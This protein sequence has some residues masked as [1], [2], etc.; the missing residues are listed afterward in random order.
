MK[1]FGVSICV[2]LLI[3]LFILSSCTTT[4]SSSSPTEKKLKVALV[5]DNRINDH[6]WNQMAY[7]GLK[8]AG[9]Q[10]GVETAYSELVAIADF[11]KVLRDYASKGYDL[12]INHSSIAKDAVLNTAKDYPNLKFLWTDGDTTKDNLAV[13]VP[14]S[15]ESSYLAGLL[16]GYMTKSKI[17]GM[18]GGMDIPSA[19][20]SF[21]GFEMGLKAAAPDAKLLVN[22]VGSFVD[23]PAG[24][25]AAL[26]QIESGADV[27]WGNGDGQNLGVLEACKEKNVL[28]IGAVWDQ[29]EVAPSVVL[30]SVIWGLDEGIVQVI[31]DLIDG[32]FKGDFYK[33]DIKHGSRLAPYHDNEK[34]IP[35]EVQQKIKDAEQKI[36]N[37]ELVI[38]V[39]DQG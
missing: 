23:V 19:H 33:I 8:K 20:R 27:V 15:Q 38:P 2:C 22:W 32:K 30:T 35:A 11:E 17:I 37:G 5:L 1:K 7:E 31:Q 12:I 6:G 29:Y 4:T 13:I 21:A 16:A 28:A 10:L 34:L 24:H 36:L 39:K 18:V 3:C 26:T 9:E 14:M 25:E